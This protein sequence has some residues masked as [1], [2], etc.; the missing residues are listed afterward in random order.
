MRVA[1]QALRAFVGRRQLLAVVQQVVLAQAAFE[2]GAGVDAGRRMRLEEHQVAAVLAAARMKE[3][4]EAGLEEVGRARVAGD[5][6]AQFAI[7]LVGA[8]HH[9]QRIPAHQRGQAFLDRQVAGEGRLFVHR[10]GVDVGRGQLGLPADALAPREPGQLVEHLPRPRRALRL[11]QGQEGVSP[12]GGL[13]RV[14]IVGWAATLEQG[15]H[16]VGGNRGIHSSAL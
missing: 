4:V 8:H 15:A 16:L 6:A 13:G 3:M 10:D 5:V 1:R 14:G 7:R 9:R 11:H 12:F 2:E